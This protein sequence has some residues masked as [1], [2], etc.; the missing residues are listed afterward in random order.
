MPPP[1][2]GATLPP[3]LPMPWSYGCQ[4]QGVKGQCV[5]DSCEYLASN[6][7]AGEEAFWPWPPTTS[8][9]DSM[10]SVARL[11]NPCAAA[12]FAF[13][14]WLS[15]ESFWMG[16]AASGSSSRTQPDELVQGGLTRQAI[17]EAGT[18]IAP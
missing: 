2:P 6:V 5:P 12:M 17:H 7:F 18:V 4:S 15:L 10:G 1:P 13:L 11:S 3:T 8:L 14:R 16:M 9:P